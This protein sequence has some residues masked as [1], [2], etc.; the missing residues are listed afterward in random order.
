MPGGMIPPG[1]PEKTMKKNQYRLGSSPF[2]FAPGF[3]RWAQQFY[4]E[5]PRKAVNMI[6]EGWNG[7]PRPAAIALLSGKVPFAIEGEAVVFE[8]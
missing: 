6:V 4:R 2:V 1:T 5:R 3:I 8:F 7:L